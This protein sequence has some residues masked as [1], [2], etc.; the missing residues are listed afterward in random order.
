DRL[1]DQKDIAGLAAVLQKAVAAAQRFSAKDLP[2]GESGVLEQL[3]RRLA[4]AAIDA[5]KLDEALEDVGRSETYAIA[6]TKESPEATMSVMRRSE[7][8]EARAA[9]YRAQ[10]R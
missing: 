9:V 10:K 5:G 4:N 6:A 2:S 3:Y 7:V 8:A 1:H